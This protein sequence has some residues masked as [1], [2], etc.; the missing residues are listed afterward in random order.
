MPRLYSTG[1]ILQRLDTDAH[2]TVTAKTSTTFWLRKQAQHCD[3][4]GSDSTEI[5]MWTLVWQWWQLTVLWQRCQLP[6]LS[7]WCAHRCHTNV[8]S[9]SQCCQLTPLSHRC[10]C[11]RC[12]SAVSCHR[13]HTSVHCHSW[14]NVKKTIKRTAANRPHSSFVMLNYETQLTRSNRKHIQAPL[15]AAIRSISDLGAQLT[16]TWNELYLGNSPHTGIS[17]LLSISVWVLLR[18]PIECI[19]PIE[20][21]LSLSSLLYCCWFTS[22]TH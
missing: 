16:A 3:S 8:T 13:C 12:H 4:S 7:Q 17:L 14:S 22:L 15:A 11:H 10:Q 21:S 1:E 18:P 9:L 5:T 20:L 2:S 6:L 19:P